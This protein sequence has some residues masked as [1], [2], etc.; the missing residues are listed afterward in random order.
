MNHLNFFLTYIALPVQ[1]ILFDFNKYTSTSGWF[2]VN[3]TVMGG[4]SQGSLSINHSGNAVFQGIIS[5]KNNGGFASVC[6]HFNQKDIGDYKKVKIRLRG[7]GKSYQFRAKS[8]SYDR[9]SY[10]Y[11]FQTPGQWQEIEIPL[12]EMRPRF[13]GSYLNM[14]NY[15]GK[16]ISEIAFLISNKIDEPFQ[17]EID[18]ISLN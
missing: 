1:L 13:R 14:E 9:H 4:R 12:H 3:D 6:Y 10:V 11:P 8:N 15:D 5:K 17:L 18:I 16:Q 7:D 2:T